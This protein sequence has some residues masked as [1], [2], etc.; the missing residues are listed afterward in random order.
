MAGKTVTLH[1]ICENP[2]PGQFGLQDSDHNLLPGEPIDDKKIRFSVEM[3]VKQAV[4]GQANFSGPY[5]NGNARERFLYLTNMVED[6]TLRRIKVPLNTITWK[7][8]LEAAKSGAP[9]EAS[10]DGRSTATEPLMGDGWVVKQ[11]EA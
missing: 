8:A 11:D 10:V 4:T 7:Q 1:I 2:P 6:R 9:L 5:A 3:P